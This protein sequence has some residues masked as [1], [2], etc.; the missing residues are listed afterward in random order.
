MVEAN[1]KFAGLNV[2]FPDRIY[3]LDAAKY[4]AS[5]TAMLNILPQSP[6]GMSIAELTPEM[7]SALDG[8]L[9]PGGA[10]LG[11][12]IKAVQLD[13]EARGLVV[14]SKGSPVRLYKN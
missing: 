1:T 9:F 4:R 8:P 14:R 6:P 12:W 2:N 13:L 3:P 10:T 5:R 7:A 11:W